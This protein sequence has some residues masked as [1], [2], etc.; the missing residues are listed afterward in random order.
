V[1]NRRK[2]IFPVALVVLG[3]VGCVWVLTGQGL[4]RA[5][6]WVSLVGVFLSVG[7]GAA[8]TIMGWVAWRHS[9]NQALPATTAAG[10]SSVAIADVNSGKIS[11]QSSGPSDGRRAGA[12]APPGGVTAS[13]PS[14]VAIGGAN[15]GDITTRF[16]A[17]PHQHRDD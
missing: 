5:E 16:D 2:V 3:L 14:A 6:K 17:A 7:F 1:D 13:G 9:R 8:G 11:T 10:E 15:T 4:D 12:G